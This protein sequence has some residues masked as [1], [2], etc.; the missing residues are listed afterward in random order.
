MKSLKEYSEKRKLE[1]ENHEA[2]ILYN[3]GRVF[4]HCNINSLSIFY[5]EKSIKLCELIILSKSQEISTLEFY[6]DL[7]S[8]SAMNLLSIYDNTNEIM[9][10]MEILN[11]Y[12][13]VD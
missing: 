4:A 11:K 3:F 2:E 9:K 1:G 5:F 13:V 7:L 10:A 8:K 12:L 6:K